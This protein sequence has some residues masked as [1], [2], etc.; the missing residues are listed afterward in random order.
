MRNDKMEMRPLKMGWLSK[1][2]VV[3]NKMPAVSHPPYL[4]E[5]LHAIS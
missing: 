3:K 2:L 1:Q 4:S 5:L